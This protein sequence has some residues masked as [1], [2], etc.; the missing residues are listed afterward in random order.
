MSLRS[1]P[2]LSC[3]LAACTSAPSSRAPEHVVAGEQDFPVHP[4]LHLRVEPPPELIARFGV[5]AVAV[6]DRLAVA[7]RIA[8]LN[9]M[10]FEVE[11]VVPTCGEPGA[12][13]D[14]ANQRITLCWE[15]I[16]AMSRA[17]SEPET[18]PGIARFV[19]HHEIAHALIDGLDLPVLGRE[20]DFADA[21]AALF[22]IVGDNPT[23]VRSVV[24][25]ARFFRDADRDPDSF[26][27]EHSFGEARYYSLLCLVLG[28]SPTV[29]PEIAMLIPESRA[30]RCGA[31]Y[32]QA[33]ASWDRLA[34]NLSP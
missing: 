6:E 1:L 33:R 3:V 8:R 4:W 7:I 19:A 26:W 15:M 22:M 21:Y 34:A 24:D 20:E 10:P 14:P 29:G 13:W 2:S 25:A 11:L 16:A 30:Q 5:D 23:T 32:E 18:A 17:G 31:E 9:D 27:D 12:Y 28:G